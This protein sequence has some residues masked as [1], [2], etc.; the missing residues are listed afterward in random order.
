MNVWACEEKNNQE[1]YISDFNKKTS[2][3]RHRLGKAK[4]IFLMRYVE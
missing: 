1:T 2:R 4:E 3:Q